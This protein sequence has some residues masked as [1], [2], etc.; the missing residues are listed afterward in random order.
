[1]SSLSGNLPLCTHRYALFVSYLGTKYN[2]SQRLTKRDEDTSQNTVQEAIESSL[3]SFL[4]KHRCRIT[5]SSRTDKGVHALL[6]CYTLPLMDFGLST[7]KLKIRAN[8]N[9]MQRNHDI[10]IKEVLLVPNNFHPRSCAIGRE[11]VYRISVLN[12]SR[13]SSVYK[14]YCPRELNH[15]LPITEVYRTLPLA[16]FDHL[17]AL[18]AIDILKGEHDFRSF[19]HQPREDDETV[20]N[21]QIE[22]IEEDINQFGTDPGICSTYQFHFKSKS[23]LHN[24]IRR[25][26]GC[27]ISYASMRAILKDDIQTIINEPSAQ[28]FKSPMVIAEPW[29]LYLS[30]IHWDRE[31]FQGTIKTYDDKVEKIKFYPPLEKDMSDDGESDQEK[32]VLSP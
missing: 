32:Q 1:M 27:I 13:L 3:E 24:M 7:E 21:V 19:A 18:E 26:V 25:L 20:R 10:M 14:T 31:S 28:G 29:G 17:R 11:Y 30:K 22:L 12:N 5:A 9:L 23:F 4:P 8:N 16:A 2:G 6:N 15:L